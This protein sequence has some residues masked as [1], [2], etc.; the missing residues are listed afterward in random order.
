MHGSQGNQGY[1]IV[2]FFIV[3]SF[4]IIIIIVFIFLGRLVLIHF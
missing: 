1:K 3:V 4:V 2:G